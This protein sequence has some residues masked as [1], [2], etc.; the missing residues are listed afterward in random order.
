MT[1]LTR[2]QVAELLQMPIRTIDYF[3]ATGQIPFSRVGKRGVRFSKERIIDWF[4]EREGV[5]YN[6]KTV[7]A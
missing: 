7:N 5:Q 2:E 1:V 4:N 3:V 6:R